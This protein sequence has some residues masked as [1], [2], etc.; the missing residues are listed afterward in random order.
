MSSLLQY[1]YNTQTALYDACINALTVYY[2]FIELIYL[3]IHGY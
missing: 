2:A 3:Q 1:C